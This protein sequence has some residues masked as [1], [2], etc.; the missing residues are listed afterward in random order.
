MNLIL[1]RILCFS[2]VPVGIFILVKTIRFLKPTFNGK[3]LAEISFST[4]SIDFIIEKRGLYAIWL[5]G[6]LFTRTPIAQFRPEVYNTVTQLPISLHASLMGARM[7]NGSTG[8]MQYKT[9]SADAG[10]Y[11]LEI[12]EGSGAG[13]IDQVIAGLLP[14]TKIDPNK[15]SLQIRES[16]P[17][18]YALLAIPLFILSGWCIIGCFVFGFL[19]DQI[20]P[21]LFK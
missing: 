17:S 8:R 14:K 15:F 5:K 13:P 9:F 10:T 2:M 1:A 21:E 7:N 6:K 12:K 18:Y 20:F 16:Q 4:K 19:I 11:R 3:V